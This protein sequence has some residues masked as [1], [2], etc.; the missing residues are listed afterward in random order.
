MD[1][2]SENRVSFGAS[3]GFGEAFQCR[4]VAFRLTIHDERN[5]FVDASQGDKI[6]YFLVYPWRGCARWRAD[7]NQ[8]L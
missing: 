8:I 4:I 5:D 1:V 2:G 3:K 7:H 6:L